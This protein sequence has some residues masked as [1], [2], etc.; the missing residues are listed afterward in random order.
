[1]AQ[2]GKGKALRSVA[3]SYHGKVRASQGSIL[4][5]PFVGLFVHLFVSV[6]TNQ[7]LGAVPECPDLEHIF[8]SLLLKV[9][10]AKRLPTGR[11]TQPV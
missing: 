7:I 8:Q 6:T 9:V 10:K 4:A 5:V 3:G 11:E 1:M 2:K